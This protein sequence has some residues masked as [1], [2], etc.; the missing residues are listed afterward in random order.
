MAA[1]SGACASDKTIEVFERRCR[2][3]NIHM[4]TATPTLLVR[5]S[6][7]SG[8]RIDTPLRLNHCAKG[9]RRTCRA[10]WKFRFGDTRRACAASP[11]PRSLQRTARCGFLSCLLMAADWRAPVNLTAGQTRKTLFG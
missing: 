7:A 8:K 2:R 9:Y 1:D 5:F 3:V 4:G 6:V 11:A 10:V